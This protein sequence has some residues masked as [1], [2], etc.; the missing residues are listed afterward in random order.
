MN[1]V[2]RSFLTLLALVAVACILA[3]TAHTASAQTGSPL[4][5][6][7]IVAWA[8]IGLPTLVF[9]PCATLGMNYTRIQDLWSPPVWREAAREAIIAQ[10]S[11]LN[12]EVVVSTPEM[13]EIASGPGTSVEVP[14][15]I[16]PDVDDQVQRERTAP[17]I[18]RLTAGRQRA[19]ILQRVS[20]LGATAIS[21]QISGKDP[22]RE[23]N[24][25]MMTLRRRQQEKIVKAQL[26]G[27][28][29]FSAAPAAAVGALRALRRDLFVEVAA[30]ITSA[31]LIDDDKVL[32]TLALAG[33]AKV[34]FTRGVVFM[35]SVVETALLKQQ[36]IQTITNANGEI[37]LRLYKD[38]R[39]VVDDRLTRAGT[40][41]GTPP[42]YFTVFA[43][44]GAI[45]YGE[46]PQ[47]YTGEAGEVA[48]VQL[49]TTQVSTNDV[50]IYDR[51][52]EILHVQG[53]Q[54]NPQAG[55]PAN[56]TDGGTASN[57]ELSD[58]ANWAL[59]FSDVKN[60][61]LAVLRTNG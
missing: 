49:D 35:H 44:R 45:A 26:A 33:E 3:M 4:A 17:T 51:R 9:K 15:V 34:R 10:P 18:N 19:P 29:A 59:G 46:K 55:V 20:P 56:A 24:A 22:V 8:L 27:L 14:F 40:G 38:M 21:R 31:H 6:A 32:D 13:N 53:A 41:A 43:G 16:E 12:S 1:K 58:P 37:V 50:V 2:P 25:I 47:I 60:I 57:A 42:V 5:G 61:P 39:V 54:W 11:F 52:R 28:F 48:A 36:R 23:I 7:A 30:N